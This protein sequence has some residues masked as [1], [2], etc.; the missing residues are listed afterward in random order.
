MI[1]FIYAF[2][3]TVFVW[4]TPDCAES[5]SNVLIVSIDALHPDAL[6]SKTSPIIYRQ[7]ISGAY[8]LRG[9]STDPPLTLISHTAMFTGLG[10]AESGKSDNNWQPGEPTVAKNTIF[11]LAMSNGF[12][13]GYYYSKEKLGFLVNPAVSDHRFSR[14]NAVDIAYA[15]FRKPGNHF[16][17]LHVSGLDEVG[18]VKGWLSP[19]Y[20]EELSF[21]DEMLG[22]LIDTVQRKGDYLIIITSD[23]AGH[24]T[25]HGSNHP[26]DFKLPFVIA[27]DRI[28][29]DRFRNI[30]YRVVDLKP[31]IENLLAMD[32]G[33]TSAR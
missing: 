28:K 2:I 32:P 1:K 4:V 31:M 24:G 16:V 17:F 12:L 6:S 26:D 8:T 25:V 22:T 3:L 11:N 20:L 30:P 9:I 29:P 19:E 13:T 7:M 33:Q 18:P 23:H 5:F 10:P 15:F 27:S 21:I 14:D